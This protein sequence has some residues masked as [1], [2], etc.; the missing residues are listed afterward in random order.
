MEIKL[1][2]LLCHL[3][4]VRS[5]DLEE[6]ILSK[7]PFHSGRAQQGPWEDEDNPRRIHSSCGR[8]NLKKKQIEF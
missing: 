3:A 1:L 2:L 6:W 7:L 8:L 5:F 4:F